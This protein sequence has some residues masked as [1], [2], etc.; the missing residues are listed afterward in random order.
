M[1]KNDWK[2]YAK[3]IGRIERKYFLI[4]ERATKAQIRAFTNTIRSEGIPY[5]VSQLTTQPFNEALIK[6]MQDLYK[7]AGLQ[8]AKRVSEELKRAAGQKRIGFGQNEKW[9]AEILAYLSQNILNRAILPIT[10]TT[11]KIMLDALNKGLADG[12][13]IDEIIAKIESDAGAE[14]LVRLRVRTETV[15]ASNVGHVIGARTSPYQVD[16]VWIAALDHRTRHMVQPGARNTDDLLR[17][18]GRDFA[19][20]CEPLFLLLRLLLLPPLPPVV[21]HLPATVDGVDDLIDVVLA[22]L[23]RPVLLVHQEPAA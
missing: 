17:R 13:S 18:C 6:P 3:E 1:T 4:F 19:A 23:P 16:K 8:G 14:W 2:K 12:S 22:K 11:R 20:S 9:I 10:E 21:H 5:A 15:K 7:D